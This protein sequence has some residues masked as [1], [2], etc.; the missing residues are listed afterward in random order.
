MGGGGVAA[1]PGWWWWEE[2]DL[3]M[4]EWL[5]LRTAVIMKVDGAGDKCDHDNDK[6]DAAAAAQNDNRCPSQR[7][8]LSF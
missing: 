7:P 3:G 4:R 1:A 5:R 8:R 6:R 2:K